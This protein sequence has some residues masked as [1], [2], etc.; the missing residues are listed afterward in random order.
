MDQAIELL[1]TLIWPAIILI[2]YA[3]NYKRF[4]AILSSLENRIKQGSAIEF[5]GFKVGAPMTLPEVSKDGKVTEEHL[6]LVH[7]SWRYPKKDQEF[8]KPMYCFQVIVEGQNKTLDRIEFVKYSLHKSYPNWQQIK[9]DRKNHFE[10]KELAWGASTV[11]AEIKIEGQE[12]LIKLSRFVNL[13][14][15]G[16]RLL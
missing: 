5:Q 14:D 15:T 8:G 12:E 3:T 11:R 7:S 10:L 1:K 13:S 16:E 6:A 4:K 9:H 2:V